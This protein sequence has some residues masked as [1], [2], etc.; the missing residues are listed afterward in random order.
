[1][2]DIHKN[3]DFQSFFARE[4]RNQKYCFSNGKLIFKQVIRHLAFILYLLH[5][6]AIEIILRK[7]R[8]VME[9]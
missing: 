5:W 4:A 7:L 2:T 6:N 9:P 3:L 8:K 1:M